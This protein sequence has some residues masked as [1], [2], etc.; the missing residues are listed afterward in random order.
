MKKL[1]YAMVLVFAVGTVMADGAGCDM[2]SKGKAKNVQ[3]TGTVVCTGSGDE[4]SPEFR[5]ANS[6]LKYEVCHGSKV[7]GKS[8]TTSNATYKVT[9]KIIKCGDGEALVIEKASKI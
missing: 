4:C 9:G 3:L 2:K 1:V 8:L 7:D 5:V 6:D